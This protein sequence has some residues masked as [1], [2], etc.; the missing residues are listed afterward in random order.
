[1]HLRN[2]ESRLK[3][4][5][6]LFDLRSTYSEV[7]RGPSSA[8]EGYGIIDRSLKRVENVDIENT[9]VGGEETVDERTRKKVNTMLSSLTSKVIEY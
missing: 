8:K 5:N 6:P 4:A 9:S 3:S 1:M 2:R 7:L